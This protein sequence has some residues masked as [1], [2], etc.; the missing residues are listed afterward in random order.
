MPEDSA[1]ASDVITDKRALI[2]Y[3][4]SGCK[5][6]EKWRIGTEHEK[7]AYHLSDLTQLE[8]E[9]EAGVR[10]LLEGLTKFGWQPVLENGNPI[11]LVKP[12]NS[13]ITLEPA[14]QVELSG[15]PLENIHQTCSEVSEHLKQ[16]KNVAKELGIGFIGLGYQPKWTREQAPWMPKS[17][18]KIMRE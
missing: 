1:P 8:Y 2:E 12:D 3:M 14:G 6:P 10:A 4:E 7:F 17:R 9:G 18:Y 11:A 13:S 15:A 16:V 5:P